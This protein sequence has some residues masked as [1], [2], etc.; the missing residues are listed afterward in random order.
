MIIEREMATTI[1]AQENAAATAALAW[2]LKVATVRTMALGM[3]EEMVVWTV[4]L[5]AAA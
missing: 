5:A 1:V 3:A 2:Q 4:A